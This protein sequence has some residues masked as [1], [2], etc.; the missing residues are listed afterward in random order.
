MLSHFK[1]IKLRYFIYGVVKIKNSGKD[2]YKIEAKFA[3]GKQKMNTLK[4]KLYKNFKMLQGNL[5]I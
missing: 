2:L 5:M 1:T 3:E 4:R